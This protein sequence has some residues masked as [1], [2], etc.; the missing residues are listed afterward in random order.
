MVCTFLPFK[1]ECLRYNHRMYTWNAKYFSI[2]TWT[3]QPGNSL[4]GCLF[5]AYCV[6]YIKIRNTTSPIS[7]ILLFLT[8]LSCALIQI[9]SWY[10]IQFIKDD[11][12]E[13]TTMVN[14]SCTSFFIIST[15][16]LVV[17]ND[18]PISFDHIFIWLKTHNYHQIIHW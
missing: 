13:D 5:Q 11:N 6:D 4:F 2:C 17:S 8:F 18:F 9:D 12:V 3:I 15:I 16:P 1:F 10:L 7:I 14:L